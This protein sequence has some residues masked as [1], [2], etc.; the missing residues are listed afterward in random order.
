MSAPTVR[1]APG[2]PAPGATA[3]G[4]R[5]ASAARPGHGARPVPGGQPAAPAVQHLLVTYAKRD[6]MRFASHRDVGRAFERAVRQAGIPMAR[7]AGFNPHPKISYASGTQTGV[8]SEAEYLTLALTVAQDPARLRSALDTALPDGID[9]IE[10]REDAGGT[11]NSRLMMSEW[12]VELPGISPEAAA[13]AA[14]EFLAAADAH[15]ER[16][17]NKGVRRLDARGAVLTMD[18]GSRASA[19]HSDA[20]AII[21]MVIRHTEPAVRPEDVLVALRQIT[22]LAPASPPAVTR[23]AQGVLGNDGLVGPGQPPAMAGHRR[24]ASTGAAD[25]DPGDPQTQGSQTQASPTQAPQAG[26]AGPGAAP[27][28]AGGAAPPDAATRGAG[29]DGR[30][31]RAPVRPMGRGPVLQATLVRFSA[32]RPGRS[33]AARH[34][35]QSSRP[36]A[37]LRQVTNLGAVA[38]VVAGSV[39]GCGNDMFP[40]GAQHP[41]R[42]RAPGSLT[43]DCPDA[44]ERAERQR[45]Q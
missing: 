10:V 42:V 37:E 35:E 21:R 44:R 17:T 6:R 36:R 32:R 3:S 34:A 39:Q 45:I 4:G 15:V 12:L 20:C 29:T 7:S 26:A 38:A 41:S 25:R 2:A 30:A 1:R 40:R 11:L 13:A 14:R 8:A 43:G 31:M 18:A 24:C 19:D 9:V 22:G 33:A 23:V 5:P 27:P 28:G 16:L